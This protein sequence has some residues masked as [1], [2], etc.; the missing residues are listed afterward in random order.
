MTIDIESLSLRELGALVVAAEQRRQLISSR[1]PASTVR[2]MLK[3]AAAEAGYTL[4]ELFG[5]ASVEEPATPR[6][7]SRRKA[8]KVAA[9]YRDPEYKRLTWSGRGRMPRWLAAKVQKGHKV[10]DFLIPGLARPT[11]RKGSPI[12]QRTVF[13]KD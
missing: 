9:K 8:G 7:S 3:A 6:K 12:G 4:E 10:T 13:K 11:A 2:R 1:R 5:D